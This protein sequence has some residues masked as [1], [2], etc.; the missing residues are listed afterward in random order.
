VSIK[1][2]NGSIEKAHRRGVPYLSKVLYVSIHAPGSTFGISVEA[3]GEFCGRSSPGC[4]LGKGILPT[5][6]APG[7]PET[8]ETLPQSLSP[9]RQANGGFAK[10]A[11]PHRTFPSHLVRNHQ[12]NQMLTSIIRLNDDVRPDWRASCHNIALALIDPAT[13]VLSAMA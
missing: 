3:I 1:I 10:D 7:S 9:R 13:G 8:S 4:P 6:N 12:T 11:W 2:P 5:A